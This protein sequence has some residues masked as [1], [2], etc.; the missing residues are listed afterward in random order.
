MTRLRFELPNVFP[1]IG[2]Q[3]SLS[4]A[5][6]ALPRNL[7]LVDSLSLHLVQNSQRMHMR[8]AEQGCEMRV[9]NA[10]D[11]DLFMILVAIEDAIDGIMKLHERR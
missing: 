11:Y 7:H 8:E 4:N 1:S 10:R 3:G 9:T 5:R 2:Q 6:P